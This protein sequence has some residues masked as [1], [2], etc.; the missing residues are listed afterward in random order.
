MIW[1]LGILLM[2]IG[3]IGFII[4]LAITIKE[5]L[6]SLKNTQKIIKN[7]KSEIESIQQKGINIT[8][9]VQIVSDRI[10]KFSKTIFIL[11]ILLGMINKKEEIIVSTS[12]NT[13]M[14]RLKE[15]QKRI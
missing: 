10:K 11:G 12:K 14:D 3:I 2:I 4:I 1:K 6:Q 7:K 9:N 8:Q 5:M 15:V 13:W